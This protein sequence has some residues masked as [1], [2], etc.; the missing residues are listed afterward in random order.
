MKA[1]K[2]KYLLNKYPKFFDY[3]SK[4][5]DIKHFS[6]ESAKKDLKDLINQESIVL[7]IQFGFEIG[8]GWFWL[9]KNVFQS[10]YEYCKANDVEIPHMTD[11]KEKYGSLSI[12]YMGGDRLIDG[13]VWFAE[14]LSSKICEECG[15][16]KNVGRTKEWIYT[17]CKT[18]YENKNDN[19]LTWFINEK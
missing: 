15:T 3:I 4:D 16:N 18:C 7:P 10:I 14:D 9:L 11:I 2:Q 5:N 12:N 1:E 8:D 6:E 17:V 13:I 19:H